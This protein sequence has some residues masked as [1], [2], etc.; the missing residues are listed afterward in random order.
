MTDPDLGFK[1]EFPGM[2]KVPQEC[3]ICNKEL[4]SE[5]HNRPVNCCQFEYQIIK[6][7]LIGKKRQ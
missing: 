1:Y 4:S 3:W 2:M 5:I 6:G 7:E